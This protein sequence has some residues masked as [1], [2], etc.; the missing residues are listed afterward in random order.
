MLLALTI[1]LDFPFNFQFR[2]TISRDTDTRKISQKHVPVVAT[3]GYTVIT[4]TKS[5]YHL[6]KQ[7]ICSVFVVLYTTMWWKRT[8][9][10]LAVYNEDIVVEFI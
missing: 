5:Q 3:T 8:V 9:R 6:I 4:R 7:D 1:E 10:H 2:G